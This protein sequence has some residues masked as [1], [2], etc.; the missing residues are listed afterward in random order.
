MLRRHCDVAKARHRR[1]SPPMTAESVFLTMMTLAG[2]LYAAL[3]MGW[4]AGVAG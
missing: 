3:Q 1:F 2:L 4:L